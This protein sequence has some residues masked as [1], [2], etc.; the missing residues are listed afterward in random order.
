MKINSIQ[1][2]AD[3]D[4]RLMHVKYFITD[5][6]AIVAVFWNFLENAEGYSNA[7]SDEDASQVLSSNELNKLTFTQV[8]TSKQL[9]LTGTNSYWR[10]SDIKILD[11]NDPYYSSAEI[12]APVMWSMIVNHSGKISGPYNK[13]AETYNTKTT[14]IRDA[15]RNSS[16]ILLTALSSSNK[17][18]S[19]SQCR[20]ALS[21]SKYSYFDANISAE[22]VTNKSTEE[23]TI[24][25][26]SYIPLIKLSGNTSIAA[27]QKTTLDI[28]FVD[29]ETNLPLTDYSANV[30]LQTTGAYINKQRVFVPSS[31]TTISVRALDMEAGDEFKVKAGYRNYTG[32]TEIKYK[33]V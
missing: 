9:N 31:G 26:L 25:L 12:E 20:L 27:D 22:D 29:P 11:L 23:R 17:P 21:Y 33:V 13:Y 30:Y 18:T 5:S 7:L 2:K 8:F 16:I 3:I 32:V 28:S 1:C 24:D 14:A 6:K 4:S 15:Y 10:V 19:F